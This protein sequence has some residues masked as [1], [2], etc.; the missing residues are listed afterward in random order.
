MV[1]VYNAVKEAVPRQGLQQA[2]EA[3]GVLLRA[4]DV[5]QV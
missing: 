1:V 2:N 5:E 4:F 3:V